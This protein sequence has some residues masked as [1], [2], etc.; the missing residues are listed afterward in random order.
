MPATPLLKSQWLHSCLKNSFV[1]TSGS[2]QHPPCPGKCARSIFDLLILQLFVIVGRPAES[3]IPDLST[4]P[5]ALFVAPTRSYQPA[6]SLSLTL[7]IQRR[8]NPTYRLT[9]DALYRI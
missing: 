8:K 6:F 1:S 4:P 2:A 3:E 5:Q 9:T 7:P